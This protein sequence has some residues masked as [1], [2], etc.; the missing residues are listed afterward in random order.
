MRMRYPPDALVVSL[1]FGV[2]SFLVD[3]A[4]SPCV[5]VVGGENLCGLAPLAHLA[6]FQS[7]WSGNRILN[8]FIKIIYPLKLKY[9]NY[10]KIYLGAAQFF[11]KGRTTLRSPPVSKLFCLGFLI[12]SVSA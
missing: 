6:M 11:L 5:Y 4:C 9:I 3:A 10:I 2:V 7:Y 12:S 1:F 8:T